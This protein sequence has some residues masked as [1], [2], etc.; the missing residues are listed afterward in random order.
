MEEMMFL[1]LRT[2]E[3]VSDNAFREAFGCGIVDIYG[4]LPQRLAK[5]GLMICENGRYVLTDRGIDIS[6]T[7]LAS[8]LLD[9]EPA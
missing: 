6:N 9:R 7:V 2:A 5:E 8:F 3:G 1:G 4:S